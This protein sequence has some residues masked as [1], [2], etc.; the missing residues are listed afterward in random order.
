M[1]D[2]WIRGRQSSI[3]EVIMFTLPSLILLSFELWAVSAVQVL[4][5]SIR[6]PLIC[7]YLIRDKPRA[8]LPHPY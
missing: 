4:L 7:S 3:S 6:V 8:P 1:S 2:E 5:I